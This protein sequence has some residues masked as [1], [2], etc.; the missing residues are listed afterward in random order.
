MKLDTNVHVLG[1]IGITDRG[2]YA[3][4]Q[5][6]PLVSEIRDKLESN[7]CFTR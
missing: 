5:E 1:G 7:L 2:V 4:V 6:R 3:T